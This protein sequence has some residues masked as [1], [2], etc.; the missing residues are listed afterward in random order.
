MAEQGPVTPRLN[1]NAQYNYLFNVGPEIKL[2]NFYEITKCHNKCTDM[3][4]S[5]QILLTSSLEPVHPLEKRSCKMLV[6]KVQIFIYTDMAI[7][8]LISL[9]I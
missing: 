2:F 7:C 5:I 1:H 4:F 9:L 8:L 3:M 6:L